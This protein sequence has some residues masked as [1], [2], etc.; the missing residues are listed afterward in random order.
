MDPACIVHP[1]SA[2]GGDNREVLDS[3]KV[4]INDRRAG[5]ETAYVL[6][7]TYTVLPKYAVCSVTLRQRNIGVN[8]PPAQASRSTR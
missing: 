8:S 2:P 4:M 3:P 7:L 6:N 5:N 1:V